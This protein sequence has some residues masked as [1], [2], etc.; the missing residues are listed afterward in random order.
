MNVMLFACF[1]KYKKV[2]M[3]YTKNV[4][5]NIRNDFEEYFHHLDQNFKKPT[6]NVLESR[7]MNRNIN[8]KKELLSSMWIEFNIGIKSDSHLRDVQ[9]QIYEHSKQ[10]E[11]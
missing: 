9:N 8:L 2:I 1:R 11:S 10:K 7:S 3:T 5:I 6:D 4:Y